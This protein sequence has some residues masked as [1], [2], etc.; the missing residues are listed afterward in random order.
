MIP[1]LIRAKRSIQEECCSRF[2]SG[3]HIN[4]IEKLDLMASNKVRLA[5][6]IRRTDGIWPKPQ[7]R[8]GY[9]PGFFGVVYKVPLSEVVCS[10]PDNLDGIF[11]C[12][13]C[14]VRTQSIKKCAGCSWLFG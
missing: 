7:M 9:R 8:N 4:A 12:A 13:Y 14:P 1:N 3:K 10:L 11:V 6:E 5:D 2:R